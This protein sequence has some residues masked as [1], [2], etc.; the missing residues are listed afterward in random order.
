MIAERIVDTEVEEAVRP[1][2]R[3]IQG[4]LS[5][6]RT[7]SF[8]QG[9]LPWLAKGQTVKLPVRSVEGRFLT[10]AVDTNPVFSGLMDRLTD[11]QQQV[12]Q[13]VF[14]RA[15]TPEGWIPKS[16]SIERVEDFPQISKAIWS[17]GFTEGF[18]EFFL[19][20]GPIKGNIGVLIAV[21][22]P[23]DSK[24]VIAELQRAKAVSEGHPAIGDRVQVL[25]P[26]IDLSGLEHRTEVTRLM[27][28]KVIVDFTRGPKTYP[29]E[30]IAERLTVKHSLVRNTMSRDTIRPIPFAVG[31]RMSSG[32][33]TNY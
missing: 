23:K 31:T 1:E 17:N 12:A 3:V 21:C 5:E 16:I 25:P 13:A 11:G 6:G 2:L 32:V 19:D 33:A 14:E 8:D 18:D 30:P 9:V 20:Y 28:E 4:G 10:S 26:G 29:D 15:A 22:N 7:T 24:H 27:D